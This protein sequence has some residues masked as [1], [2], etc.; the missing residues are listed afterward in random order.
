MGSHGTG[1][2]KISSNNHKSK[3]GHV[4]QCGRI[5]RITRVIPP[6]SSLAG[7]RLVCDVVVCCRWAPVVPR[8]YFGSS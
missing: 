1:G 2:L 5:E 6:A 8:T 3:T 4:A 7:T